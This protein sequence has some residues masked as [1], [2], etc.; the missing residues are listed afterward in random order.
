MVEMATTVEILIST[1]GEIV[2]DI[3]RSG[4][5]KP[6]HSTVKF[7]LLGMPPA[8]NFPFT[9]AGLAV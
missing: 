3:N 8:M 5:H 6:V 9:G 2:L 1:G 4:W 7:M